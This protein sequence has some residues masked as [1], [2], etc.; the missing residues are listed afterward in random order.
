MNAGIVG[1]VA[2]TLFAASCGGDLDCR[3]KGEECA[4]GFSCEDG[5]KGAWR[6][7]KR[8]AQAAAENAADGK[9]PARVSAPAPVPADAP[10]PNHPMCA[11]MTAECVCG[12]DGSLLTR[13]LDRDRDG[14]PDEKAEY[15]NDAEGRVVQV[16]VDEG[17][18][19]TPDSQHSYTYNDQGNPLVWQINR[20]SK[21]MTNVKDQLLTYEY[22]VQGNLTQEKVDI[23]I[24]KSIDSTCTYSPPCPP[25]IPNASC[26]PVCK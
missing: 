11:G 9:K 12:P 25:P 22:D 7:E 18:D 15:S 26:R 17:M 10:C 23:G 20:L 3:H 24:D 1:L 6:C 4:E 21:A 5:G 2:A 19:G 16:I 13:T 14:K 8:P